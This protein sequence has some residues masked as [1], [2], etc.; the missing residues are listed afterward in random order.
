M[1]QS[2]NGSIDNVQT[3]VTLQ[4]SIIGTFNVYNSSGTYLNFEE[5]AAIK[6]D[7]EVMVVTAGWGT[8][9]LTVIRNS[10]GSIGGA[11]PHG[12]K[13]TVHLVWNDPGIIAVTKQAH[14]QGLTVAYSPNRS[15]WPNVLT[16]PQLATTPDIILYEAQRLQEDSNA[17]AEWVN[18]IGNI[19]SLNP[20]VK[21][22]FQIN[23]FSFNTKLTYPLDYMINI[24]SQIASIIGP[25]WIT[26][27]YNGASTAVFQ[28]T[29]QHYRF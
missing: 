23:A 16:Y 24:I 15:V 9:S 19:R 4:T 17:M 7:N 11:A 18:D 10:A 21:I 2:L 25:D 13:A 26:I 1:V 29:I 14:A 28:K 6:V 8:S 3:T 22:I 12:D 27:E 20:L 5:T